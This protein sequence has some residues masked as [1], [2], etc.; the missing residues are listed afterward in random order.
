LVQEHRLYPACLALV[1]TRRA[2]LSDGATLLDGKHGA[3][4][5]TQDGAIV[6]IEA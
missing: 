1:A 5:M 2:I 4:A 6:N 3:L